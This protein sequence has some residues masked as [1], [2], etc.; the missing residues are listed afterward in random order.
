ME[1]ERI[2]PGH[3]VHRS[4][5]ARLNISSLGSGRIESAINKL[6]ELGF[7]CK[8]VDDEQTLLWSKLVFLGPLALAT[9]AANKTTG[10][11]AQDEALTR[12]LQDCVREA[13]AV[14]QSEG[15]VV[16]PESVISSINALPP[17]L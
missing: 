4:P 11:I 17:K 5:F 2:S 1:S 15:A 14:A 8:F 10:E 6:R 12:Q 9:T 3:I 16:S 7:T 13:C